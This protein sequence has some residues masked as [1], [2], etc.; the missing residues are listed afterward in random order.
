MSSEEENKDS[1][2]E[3]A[4]EAPAAVRS[5]FYHLHERSS[6][7]FTLL[8]HIRDT[9][10]FIFFLAPVFKEKSA[11]AKAAPRFEVKKWN[12]V[13]LWSWDICADTVRKKDD[14]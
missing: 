11:P 5:L 8:S 12:A 13:A 4:G 1:E 10:S 9:T 7:F 3:D 2:M 14:N 6:S